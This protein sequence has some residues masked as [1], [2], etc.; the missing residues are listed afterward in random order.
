MRFLPGCC[1]RSYMWCSLGVVRESIPWTCVWP[2]AQPNCDKFMNQG[3]WISTNMMRQEN[4]SRTRTPERPQKMPQGIFF[5]FQIMRSFRFFFTI[6]ALNHPQFIHPPN[7][8]YVLVFHLNPHVSTVSNA[9][10]NGRRLA[11]SRREVRRRAGCGET[12]L[13]NVCC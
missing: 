4:L 5:S 9:Y 7:G 13:M 6:Q 11:P 8:L 2:V 1:L 10:P 3:Y 12:I